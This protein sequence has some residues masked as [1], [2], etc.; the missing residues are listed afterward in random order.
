MLVEEAFSEPFIIP[1]AVTEAE[2]VRT[3][4]RAHSLLSKEFSHRI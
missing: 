4:L 3:D 2:D 1:P